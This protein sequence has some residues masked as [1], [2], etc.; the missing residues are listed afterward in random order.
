MQPLIPETK[1]NSWLLYCTW[2]LIITFS[3]AGLI[4]KKQFSNYFW[5]FDTCIFRIQTPLPTI[6]SVH[7]VKRGEWGGC[8]KLCRISRD[9]VSFPEL[10][11]RHTTKKRKISQQQYIALTFEPQRPKNVPSDMCAQRTFRSAC[12]FAQSESS[13]GEF[14]A[15]PGCTISACGQWRLWS[16]CAYAQSDQSLRW[17]HMS[18]R[19]VSFLE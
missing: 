19:F 18:G 5:G 16:D 13:P 6:S 15:S 2:L 12:A 14:L 9:A 1:F 8:Q 4:N 7:I 17:A 11:F 10:I 3:V